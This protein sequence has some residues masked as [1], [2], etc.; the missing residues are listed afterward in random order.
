[1]SSFGAARRVLS[2]AALGGT[3]MAL[4]GGALAGLLVTEAKLARRWVGVPKTLPPADDGLWGTGP[5]VPISFV[6]IGDS[7]AAGLGVD[8]AAETPGAQIAQGL[9]AAADRPVRLTDVALVGA[10]SADL[11]RQVTLALAAAPDVALIMIGA[12]DITHRVSLTTAVS[13]LDAAVRRLREAGCEVVVG[14]CPDLGTIEPIAQ[15]LR[16]LARRWSRQLAAAQTI[17]V[18]EA[19]GRTVSLGDLIGPEFSAAPHEMFSADRFHP[20]AA[21]YASAAVAVLPAVCAAL[22]YWAAD[23]FDGAAEAAGGLLPVAF[24][25]VEAVEAPGT[26]VAPLGAQDDSRHGGLRG[27][28]ALLRPRRRL[29]AEADTAQPSAA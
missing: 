8:N 12:N 3:G 2:A 11:D 13:Q 26:Q 24:A 27:P 18:V 10:R 29:A 19:G 21:G 22:G 1:M 7:S 16:Y 25:A 4:T 5:G 28:W 17:V 15:P 6:V 23:E 14:T 9:S 20:S